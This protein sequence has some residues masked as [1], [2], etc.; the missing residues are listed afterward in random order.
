[1]RYRLLRSLSAAIKQVC[2]A[3][4]RALLTSL[5]FGIC[6]VALMRYLGVPVPSPFELFR[7]V[8]GLSKLAKILS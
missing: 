5:V 8:E 2:G 7:D 4:L 1:M 3:V 6:V